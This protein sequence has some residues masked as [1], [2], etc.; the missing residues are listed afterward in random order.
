[1]KNALKPVLGWYVQMV[2]SVQHCT[3]PTTLP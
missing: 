1:L 2:M 3:K